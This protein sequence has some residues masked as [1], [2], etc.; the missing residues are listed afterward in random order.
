LFGAGVTGAWIGRLTALTAYQPAFLVAT[1]L[2]LGGGFW[3]VHRAE[4]R[5]CIA[6]QCATRAR[7]KTIRAALW[8][9]TLLAA[10]AYAFPYGYALFGA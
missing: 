1:I 8:L 3:L 9:A 4:R 10:T 7:P 5:A 6:D 2:C